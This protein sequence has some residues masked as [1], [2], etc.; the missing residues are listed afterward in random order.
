METLSRYS[1]QAYA[2][3]R[4][5]F[6]FLFLQHGLQKLFGVLGGTQQALA[7]TMGAA[8]VIEAAGGLLILIG[9]QTAIVAFICCG[10]MA[11]AYFS[12]HQPGGLL[13]IQ[14]RGELAVLYCFA[15]L[16]IATRGGGIWSVDGA[17]RG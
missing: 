11:F 8:G 13:P 15:F 2:L 9:L 7:S 17:G 1:P 5:V 3:F 12:A 6:G 10:E 4:M 16:Y 14:N